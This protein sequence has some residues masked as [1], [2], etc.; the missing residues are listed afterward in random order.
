MKMTMVML[1][2]V[3]LDP[4]DQEDLLPNPDAQRLDLENA[5]LM[6]ELTAAKVG[7]WNCIFTHY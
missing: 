1:E 4:L 7:F 5:V 6:Q 3:H 2:S